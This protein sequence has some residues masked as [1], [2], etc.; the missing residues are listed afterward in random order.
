MP[1][2]VLSGVSKS[3]GA[4][5][6]RTEVLRDV[7]LT[8][9]KGEVISGAIRCRPN[10]KNHRDLDIEI[11]YKFEGSKSEAVERVQP[12]FK[13]EDGAKNFLK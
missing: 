1:F 6:S 11:A 12:L 4:P 10:S 13:L 7:S 2:L 9:E 8:V 5:D 3:F